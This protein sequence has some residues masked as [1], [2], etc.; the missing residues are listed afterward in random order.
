MSW[1]AFEQWSFKTLDSVQTCELLEKF[2]QNF[3]FSEEILEIKIYYLTKK[4][5][6]IK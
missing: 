2:E 3:G 6:S 1:N 4:K 5:V